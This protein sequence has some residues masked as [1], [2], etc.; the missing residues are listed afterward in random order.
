MREAIKEGNTER[1]FKEWVNTLSSDNL[2]PV[3]MS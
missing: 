2:E 3:A 1:P